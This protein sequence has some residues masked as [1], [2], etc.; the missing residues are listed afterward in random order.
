MPPS[1]VLY[2]GTDGAPDVQPDTVYA[3]FRGNI[4]STVGGQT[5]LNTASSQRA[6]VGIFQY[7]EEDRPP[8]VCPQLP[9]IPP[10]PAVTTIGVN[11]LPDP[12]TPLGLVDVGAGNSEPTIDSIGGVGNTPNSDEDTLADEVDNCRSVANQD[13]LDTGRFLE[14]LADAIGN[15]CQCGN[16]NEVNRGA[17]FP[18]DLGECLALL[19]ADDVTS[20]NAKRCSVAI[21]GSFDIL[22]VTTL[23]IALNQQGNCRLPN[24]DPGT[25]SKDCLKDSDCT[26]PGEL[27]LDKL[28]VAQECEQAGSQ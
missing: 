25:S 23:D 27:C 3:V 18:E 2:P 26:E 24:A 17:I 15:V 20:Q 22:D 1:Y 16:S 19:A 10:Q 6:L 5:A 8:T 28:R 12:L 7:A 9:A 21:D 4:P 14:E 11:L 13:Q